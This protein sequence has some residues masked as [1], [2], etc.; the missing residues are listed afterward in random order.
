MADAKYQATDLYHQTKRELSDQADTQQQRI[1]TGLRGMGDDLLSM[2]RNSTQQGMAS[3]LVREVSH[4][5]SRAGSWLGSRD[6]NGVMTEVKGYARRSPGTFILAAAVTGVVVGRLTRALA[7]NASDQHDAAQLRSRANGSP[8]SLSATDPT[9]RIDEV[10]DTPIY[11]QTSPAWHDETST[12]Y[13][14]G[15]SDTI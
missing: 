15:R 6:F 3:D 1:A 13:G 5:V 12:E 2:A 11:A 4:R 10:G 14:D 9:G 8:R 7:S